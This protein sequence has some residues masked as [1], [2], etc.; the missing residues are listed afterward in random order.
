MIDKLIYIYICISFLSLYTFFQGYKEI[1][2]YIVALFQIIIFLIY[3]LKYIKE[4]CKKKSL[5]ILLLSIVGSMFF[6]IRNSIYYISN[7]IVIINAYILTK[8]KWNYINKNLFSIANIFLGLNIFIYFFG[9]KEEVSPKHILGYTLKKIILR[10]ISVGNFSLI[11]TFSLAGIFLMRKKGNI[12]LVLLTSIVFSYINGKF[13]NILAIILSYFCCFIFRFYKRNMLEI[14]LK[15]ITTLCF[16]STFIFI[17]IE[18]NI[19]QFLDIA[20]IFSGRQNIWKEF[21][22]YIE[23]SYKSILWGN[24]F[25][26]QKVESLSISHPHNQYLAILYIGGIFVYVSFIFYFIEVSKK[27]SYCRTKNKQYIYLY[28]SLLIQMCGDDYFILTI[29]PLVTLVFMLVYNIEI[30]NKIIKSRK[31]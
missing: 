21:I 28:I 4:I 29:N 5:F 22:A 24:G 30:K 8:K 9:A 13:T 3:S 14:F 2:L 6:N 18:K 25:F 27:I 17:E 20:N 7:A 26:N 15:V 12:L 23:R 19:S 11:I 10:D 31:L 1:M 16:F